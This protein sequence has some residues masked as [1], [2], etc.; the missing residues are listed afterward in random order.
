VLGRDLAAVS[1]SG[2]DYT[3]RV[4]RPQQGKC[5]GKSGQPSTDDRYASH[6]ENFP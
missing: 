2:F 3:H 5:R 1:F 4:P 6:D